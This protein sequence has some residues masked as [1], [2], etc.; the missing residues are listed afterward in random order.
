EVRRT[1]TKA[2]PHR[3]GPCRDPVACAEGSDRAGATRRSRRLH[4]DHNRHPGGRRPAK[5]LPGRSGSSPG[6]R[7]QVNP[8]RPPPGGPESPGGPFLRICGHVRPGS[9]I[10]RMPMEVDVQISRVNCSHTPD[11]MAVRL[12]NRSPLMAQWEAH[13]SLEDFTLALTGRGDVKGK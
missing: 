10:T 11:Y 1:R 5:D 3:P 4:W 7:S 9:R 2:H 13:V 6:G 8:T 12:V